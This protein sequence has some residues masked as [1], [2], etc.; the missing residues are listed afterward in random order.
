MEVFVDLK[1]ILAITMIIVIGFVIGI[2]NLINKFKN[3]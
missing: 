3:K 2:F 1:D